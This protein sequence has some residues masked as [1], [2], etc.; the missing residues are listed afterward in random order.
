MIGR[1][2]VYVLIT[3]YYIFVL[4]VIDKQKLQSYN[5]RLF[6]KM[7]EI[8]VDVIQ[9]TIREEISTFLRSRI[10]WRTLGIYMETTSKLLLG[11][12]SILTFATS[13]Y[14]CNTYLSFIAGAVSTLSLVSLQFANYSFRESKLSTNNLNL[15]LSKIDNSLLVPECNGSVLK[16]SPSDSTPKQLQKFDLEMNKKDDIEKVDSKKDDIEKYESTTLPQ[17]YINTNSI[18]STTELTRI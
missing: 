3:M 13:I 15:L 7:N 2:Y 12:T 9:P 16:N 11:S 4:F 1:I 10:R 5:I 6:Y 14:P 18:I 8:Q 17:L